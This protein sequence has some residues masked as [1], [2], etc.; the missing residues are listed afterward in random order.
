[1]RKPVPC[2]VAPSASALSRPQQSV[3][4][5]ACSS[6]DICGFFESLMGN[7]SPSSSACLFC[8]TTICSL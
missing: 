8:P 2:N 1:M 5:T 3:R 4:F 6:L 7:V